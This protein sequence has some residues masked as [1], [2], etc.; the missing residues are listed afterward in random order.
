MAR[1]A[2]FAELLLLDLARRP[3]RP[4]FVKVARRG[5]AAAPTRAGVAVSA[6]LGSIP[7]TTTTTRGS[8]SPASARGA[9]P[10]RGA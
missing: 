9:P 8:S 3:E 6:Y 1:I 10:R 7:S 4:A 5:A 2:D